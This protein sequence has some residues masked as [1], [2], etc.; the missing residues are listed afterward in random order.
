MTAPILPAK[1]LL[2]E[3]Q[4]DEA[5]RYL[6]L[7]Y[8]W[9]YDGRSYLL[10]RGENIALERPE[11]RTST[12]PAFKE[13]HRG[14]MATLEGRVHPLADAWLHRQTPKREITFDPKGTFRPDVFNFWQGWAMTP[15]PLQSWT[16]LQDHVYEIVCAANVDLYD[17]VMNWCARLIQM[18]WEP[19][20]T[21]IVLRGAQGVGKGP[22]WFAITRICG[23]HA[24]HIAHA[25]SLSSRFNGVL[26]G[27]VFLHADEVVWGGEIISA[28]YLKA[29]MTEPTISIERKGQEVIQVKNC[30]HIVMNSNEQ[31]VARVEGGDRRYAV[32]DVLPDR[33]GQ[34][35]TYFDPLWDACRNGA[36]A[37]LMAHLLSRDL[38][39]FDPFVPP[40]TRA[41][42][43]QQLRSM[44]P[45]EEWFYGCL[46]VGAIGDALFDG[47]VQCKAAF[48][49]YLKM[50]EHRGI[51]RRSAETDLG[52]MINKIFPGIDKPR[53]IIAPST[54]REYYW[55]LPD[56]GEAR[57]AFSAF[58]RTV[59][60][61][62]ADEEA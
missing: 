9:I 49:H 23:A 30:L 54:R 18:P 28:N 21:S 48:D 10:V 4:T 31:H 39:G 46:R 12:I 47:D 17:F 15:D 13:G 50:M 24:V 61:W 19:A 2:D 26:A 51:S 56:L 36:P 5:L 8:H 22:L 32:L 42:L 43:E 1:G 62:P 29:L 44:S 16:I 41:R 40:N 20:G 57:A 52:I 60:E 3:R 35:L 7:H 59:Y 6:D 25:G 55:R 33:A 14:Y 58:K 53:R 11:W 34:N 37:G 45:M 38:T 27:C